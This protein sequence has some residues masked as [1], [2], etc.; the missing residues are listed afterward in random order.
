MILRGTVQFYVDQVPPA[1]IQ[2]MME[3]LKKQGYTNPRILSTG[4]LG[5]NNLF[6]LRA[7][8][9]ITDDVNANPLLIMGKAKAKGMSN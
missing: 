7:D 9:T 4:D 1:E 3:L 6:V 2:Q 5:I 8:C